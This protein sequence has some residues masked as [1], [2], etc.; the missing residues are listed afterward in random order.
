MLGNGPP[1]CKAF[2]RKMHFARER[3]RAPPRGFLHGVNMLEGTKKRR[4]QQ[5]GGRKKREEE[6][7]RKEEEEGGGG[8]RRRGT[9]EKRTRRKEE[10][11]G[12]GGSRK[13]EEKRKKEESGERGERRKAEKEEK[14]EEKVK[15]KKKKMKEN[16]RQNQNKKEKKTR[17]SFLHD[18]CGKRKSFDLDCFLR[19]NSRFLFEFL[20]PL[21]GPPLSWT[22]QEFALFFPS[23]ARKVEQKSSTFF[24]KKH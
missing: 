23:P 12:K 10:D 13:K 5:G 21:P 18:L 7:K 14:E 6:E 1:A 24:E 3:H 22:A 17:K 20:D 2:L 4:E 11:K 15:K 9:R 8:R 19:Q 16:E